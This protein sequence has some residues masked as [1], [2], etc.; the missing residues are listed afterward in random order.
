MKKILVYIKN[1][2][3]V[4]LIIITL[5]TFIVGYV[6]GSTHGFN[7]KI[8]FLKSNGIINIYKYDEKDMNI[9]NAMQIDLSEY[10]MK[11]VGDVLVLKNKSKYKYSH[12]SY[13]IKFDNMNN[14]PTYNSN[15]NIDG[16]WYVVVLK[17][18]GEWKDY[19]SNGVHWSVYE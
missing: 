12:P 5:I 8:K 18:N 14:Q 13:K 19:N 16:W 1:I 9:L 7:Q 3:Y 4:I 2:G 15:N 10:A 6:C 17:Q 11:I